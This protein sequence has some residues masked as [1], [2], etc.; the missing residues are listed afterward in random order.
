MFFV[1]ELKGVNVNFFGVTQCFFLLCWL[2]HGLKPKW[3]SQ[4]P[5]SHGFRE[6]NTVYKFVGFAGY[7][8]DKVFLFHLSAPVFP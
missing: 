3:F 7:A 1:A 2:P 6:R 4:S 8:F 5:A